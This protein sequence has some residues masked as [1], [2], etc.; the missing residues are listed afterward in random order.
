MLLVSNLPPGGYP[1]VTYW[2]VTYAPVA[3]QS[4]QKKKSPR[5]S[6]QNRVE[7]R[8]RISDAPQ[9]N[10]VVVREGVLDGIASLP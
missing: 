9:V 6:P 2:L 4:I 7:L 10:V 3:Y 8:I 1:P 5:T